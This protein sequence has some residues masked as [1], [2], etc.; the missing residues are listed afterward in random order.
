MADTVL[1]VDLGRRDYDDALA[2]QRELVVRRREGSIPD[3]LV[4][5]EHP[6][7]FTIGRGASWN[8]LLSEPAAL[9]RLG[10]RLVEADRGGDITFHGP[11]QLIGYP[12]VDLARW[13]KDVHA[14]LRS[15][16]QTL[17]DALSEWGV[18]TSREAG[19][20]GVW[21]ASG[22]VAAIGVRV[23]RWVSSHGF[24]LNVSTDL[25]YFKHIVPCGIVDRSVSSM[26]EILRAPV[27]RGPVMDA[28]SGAFGRV[29]E[30]DVVE[31]CESDLEV[32][33]H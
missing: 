6:P 4:F 2:I 19:L 23:T 14:Y 3:V 32:L 15:L 9:E 22:K 7:T 25:D 29:F 31:A 11:G 8:N 16:E 13:R 33:I 10:A 20:T 24:A 28:V 1:R 21:H 27:A 5:V 30:R 18:S 12:I 17:I 26:E